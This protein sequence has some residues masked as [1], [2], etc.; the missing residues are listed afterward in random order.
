MK[1][2]KKKKLYEGKAKIMYAADSE[3]ALIQEF[4]DDATA[5]NGKK[6]GQITNKGFVNNQVSAHFFKYISS[7]HVRTH[8]LDMYSDN[9]MVVQNLKMIPLEVVMRNIAAGSLVEKL[10]LNEG[11]RLESPLL[12][13]YLKDDAK[14][15][16][17]MTK[18]E[19][20]AMELASEEDVEF[21]TRTSVKVN[22][23][24]KSFLERRG[25]LL[26]DFKVEYGK[27]KDGKIILADEI[28]PDTCRFWD[29]ETKER[30]DKDRFRKD[31]GGVEEAYEEVRRR[32]YM[33]V[34]H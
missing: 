26:V 7:F 21:I 2:K 33:E 30:L 14:G 13:F 28:S 25:I 15:D 29:A 1:V 31:M 34:S 23:I 22:A 3:T 32:V 10:S 18:E 20:L 12:E 24:L 11:D 16:P 4:K 19:I 5:F 9:A 6:T 8:F 27:N 17:Q